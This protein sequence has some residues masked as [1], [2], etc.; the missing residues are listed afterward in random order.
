MNQL[1]P[2]DTNDDATDGAD[3]EDRQIG[4]RDNSTGKADKQG[5][6]QTRCPAGQW[7]SR[8]ADQETDS[9]SIQECANNRNTFIWKRHRQH[10]GRIQQAE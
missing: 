5:Y 6:N 9:K 4:F 8:Y 1:I 10:Q 3:G 7:Q 2:N